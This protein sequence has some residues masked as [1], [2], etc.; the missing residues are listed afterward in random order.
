MTSQ[1]H[2][3]LIIK[4]LKILEFWLQIWLNKKI[5]IFRQMHLETSM[6]DYGGQSLPI[7]I[8]HWAQF[9][10]GLGSVLVLCALCYRVSIWLAK[11]GMQPVVMSSKLKSWISQ[12]E[13]T[14][15]LIDLKIPTY[16]LERKA[17]MSSKLLK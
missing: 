2:K 10:T 4:S 8:L 3:Y 16:L 7:W 15:K 5:Y 6:L 14:K 1:N 12:S 17:C 9:W 11:I 13:T